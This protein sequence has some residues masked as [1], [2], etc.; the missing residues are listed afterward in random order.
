M[1]A[2]LTSTSIGPTSATIARTLSTSV[3]SVMTPS[4]RD[5]MTTSAPASRSALATPPRSRARR[6]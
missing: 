5:A 1:P 3:T 4:E 6:R 2:L